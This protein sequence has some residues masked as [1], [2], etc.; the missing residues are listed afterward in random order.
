MGGQEP[1]LGARQLGARVAIS[2]SHH[3]GSAGRSDK[4][5]GEGLKALLPPS[6]LS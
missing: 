3:G 5:S 4:V 2:S 1:G 6:A